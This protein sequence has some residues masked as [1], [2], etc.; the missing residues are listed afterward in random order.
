MEYRRDGAEIS[1]TAL[2]CVLHRRSSLG[3]CR[4]SSTSQLSGEWLHN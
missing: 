3:A 4:F 2:Y 1:Q